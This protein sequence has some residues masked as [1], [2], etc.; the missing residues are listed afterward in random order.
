MPT[1]IFAHMCTTCLSSARSLSFP[2]SPQQF[3]VETAK[4]LGAFLLSRAAEL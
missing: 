2:Y 3:K 1:N 4:P